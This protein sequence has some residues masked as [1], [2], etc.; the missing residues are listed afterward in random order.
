MST[1]PIDLLVE[2]H[3]VIE[4]VLD[5]LA[6]RA[7]QMG[8]AAA[9]EDDDRAALSDCVTFVRGYAD[10]IHHGKEEAIL[11]GALQKHGV[12]EA[13]E[14]PLAALYRDHETAR[15]L[16]ADLGSLTQ[17]RPWSDQVRRQI[18][19]TAR[20]Y[21]SL[22]RRHIAAEDNDM[23]PAIAAALPPRIMRR[24]AAASDRFEREHAPQRA[25]LLGIVARLAATETT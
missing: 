5:V 9:D 1:S 16:T 15:L 11:F 10:A 25:A 21:T 6:A 14:A 19:R 3:R 4:S 8:T 17:R 7:E 2:E 18:Q 13:L 23:F 22:L 24:V 12:P 20:D